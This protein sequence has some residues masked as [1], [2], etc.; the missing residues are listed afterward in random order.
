M[1]I[2]FIVRLMVKCSCWGFSA[3]Q[4]F[5]RDHFLYT[6][7]RKQL[8]LHVLNKVYKIF[9]GFFLCNCFR[10]LNTDEGNP[11]PFLYLKWTDSEDFKSIISF[12]FWRDGMWISLTRYLSICEVNMQKA[13]SSPDSFLVPVVWPWAKLLTFLKIFIVD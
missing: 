8:L 10:Y 5:A 1:P 7:V 2:C 4:D 3:T 6:T 12:M 9:Q 11:A 13:G